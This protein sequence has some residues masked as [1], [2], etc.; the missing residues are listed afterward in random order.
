MAF[1]SCSPQE[2]PETIDHRLLFPVKDPGI[3]I[4]IVGSTTPPFHVHTRAPLYVRT[5]NNS[6]PLVGDFF[7][8][9]DKIRDS[10]RFLKVDGLDPQ[11]G[12]KYFVEIRSGN[13]Q[14]FAELFPLDDYYVSAEVLFWSLDPIPEVEGITYVYCVPK[15]P[16]EFAV[17]SLAQKSITE[18][19]SGLKGL[20]P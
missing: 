2:H 4:E 14:A 6:L 1:S 15:K 5:N 3:E 19:D 13:N 12:F 18:H 7:T 11:E 9:R 17:R 8:V 16:I 20:Q 10:T